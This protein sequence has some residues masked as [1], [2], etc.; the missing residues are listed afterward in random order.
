[1]IFPILTEK[2]L[3]WS[4]HQVHAVKNIR[5]QSEGEGARNILS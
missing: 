3:S 4:L 1:V 5:Y 2:Q